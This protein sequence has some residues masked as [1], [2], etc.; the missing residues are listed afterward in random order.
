MRNTEEDRQKIRALLIEL[1]DTYF[2]PK[3]DSLPGEFTIYDTSL[4]GCGL[5][6]RLRCHGSCF[7]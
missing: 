1:I 6:G 3:K 2:P 5:C 4:G 7:K